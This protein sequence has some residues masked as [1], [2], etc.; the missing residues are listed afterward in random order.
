MEPIGY[1]PSVV[2][3]H[4]VAYVPSPMTVDR[5]LFL[6]LTVYKFDKASDA[7]LGFSDICFDI[8]DWLEATG[9]VYEKLDMNLVGQAQC[10]YGD[11]G[12][13]VIAAIR[14]DSTILVFTTGGVDSDLIGTIEAA[15]KSLATKGSVRLRDTSWLPGGKW[16]VQF[17]ERDVTIFVHT[18]RADRP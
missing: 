1:V 4:Q 2:S 7:H 3:A 11:E 10:A 15:Y 18:P 13:M 8:R 14:S 5:P 16:T 9:G 12:S 6:A 17:R